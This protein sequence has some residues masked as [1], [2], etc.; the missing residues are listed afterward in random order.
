MGE[1]FGWQPGS[2]GTSSEVQFKLICRTGFCGVGGLI[3]G[4]FNQSTINVG[5]L[6]ANRPKGA[7]MQ[8]VSISHY[9]D[10]EYG[11]AAA[12]LRSVGWQHHSANLDGAKRPVQR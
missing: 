4:R 1:R 10:R 11:K 6:P 3:R 9:I 5:N 2:R 7:V 12:R 8:F